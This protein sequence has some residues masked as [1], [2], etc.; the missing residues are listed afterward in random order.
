[1]IY[2]IDPTY[3]FMSG[4][5]GDK[6]KMVEYQK[7]F[8]AQYSIGDYMISR[9]YDKITAHDKKIVPIMRPFTRRNEHYRDSEELLDELHY[10]PAS[11]GIQENDLILNLD[12]C[13]ISLINIG[14]YKYNLI[15]KYDLW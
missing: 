6:F 10:Q 9:Y 11:R 4:I 1:M 5:L 12:S 7:G 15:V 8:H 3:E 14:L 13:K 2:N